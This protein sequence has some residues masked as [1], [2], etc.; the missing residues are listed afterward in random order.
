MAVET[1]EL[2]KTLVDEVRAVIKGAP[3]PEQPPL[4]PIKAAIERVLAQPRCLAEV[5]GSEQEDKAGAGLLYEDPNYG[6]AVWASVQPPGTYHAAHDHGPT[7]AVYGVYAGKV[8]TVLYRR[9]DDGSRQGYAEVR[10]LSRAVATHGDV[11]CMPRGIAHETRS[12]DEKPALNLI[13]R[14]LRSYWRH[15]YRPDAR[16]VHVTEM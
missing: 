4:E 7:W 3:D 14:G 10:E 13:V 5:Y 9:A 16:T 15:V 2:V 12:M 6:F 11:S 8:D 1:S